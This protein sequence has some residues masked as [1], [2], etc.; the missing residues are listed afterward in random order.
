MSLEVESA[1]LREP[2]PNLVRDPAEHEPTISPTINQR[3]L[4]ATLSIGRPT[5]A[6]KK[7]PRLGQCVGMSSEREAHHRVG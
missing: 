7:P 1:G 2:E 5:K 6:M 4:I 3:F